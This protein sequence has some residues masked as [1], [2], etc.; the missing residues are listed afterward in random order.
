VS[1]PPLAV[2]RAIPG[3]SLVDLPESDQCCGGAGIYNL[4]EPDVSATV[5]G[6]K[7]AN[8]ATIDTDWIATGN[9]GCQMQIGG[10]LL[11]D[12]ARARAVHP[13]DLLDAAYAAERP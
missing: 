13:V 4:V 5:L 8:V 6:R 11:R 9:P 7:L 10:G 1:D 3:V 2:L 12:G